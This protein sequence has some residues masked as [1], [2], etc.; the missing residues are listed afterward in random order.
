MSHSGSHTHT[1]RQVTGSTVPQT[2]TQTGQWAKWGLCGNITMNH[3]AS[4][5]QPGL[6]P[7]PP[8]LAESVTDTHL[9]A[10]F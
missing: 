2:D 4:P 5:V 8:Q 3:P 6:H 9:P 10:W 1:D 7:R